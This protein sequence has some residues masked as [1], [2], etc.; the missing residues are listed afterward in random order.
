[1]RDLLEQVVVMIDEIPGVA[2]NADPVRPPLGSHAGP[3]GMPSAAAT[4]RS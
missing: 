2:R 3:L 4:V 1:V